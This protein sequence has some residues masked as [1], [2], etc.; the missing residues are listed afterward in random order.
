VVEREDRAPVG[1]FYAPGGWDERVELGEA[2][3]HHAGVKRLAVGDVVGLTS[4]DGRRGFGAIADLSRRG[5]AVSLDTASITVVHA[6]A[7]VALWA[8]VGDRDRMLMLAEK[9]VELGVSAWWP[10][11]YTRSRSVSPRGEGDAFRAKLRLRMISALEQSGGAWLPELHD[12]TDLE[13]AVA[14]QGEPIAG[15]RLLLDASGEAVGDVLHTL[16][17]P[18]TIALGPEGGLT[19]DERARFI[20]GGWR[21]VSLGANVLRF[22][23]AGIAALA[24]VRAHTGGDR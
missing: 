9:A 7:H 15:D 12:D 21:L 4:G 24:I 18:V 13:E 23:T 16:D 10:V 8:P 22:E 2:A 1:T 11:T 6:P 20:R 5:L 3:A 19:E 17:P 14:G